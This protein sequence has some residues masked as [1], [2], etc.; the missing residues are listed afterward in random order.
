VLSGPLPNVDSFFIIADTYLG[1]IYQ[2]DAKTGAT[3]ELISLVATRYSPPLTYD[4]TTKFVFWADYNTHTIN[5]YSLITNNN[6]VIYGDWSRVG[7][8]T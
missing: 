4:P 3:A 7:K 2:F 5:R 8:D 6:T 1:K